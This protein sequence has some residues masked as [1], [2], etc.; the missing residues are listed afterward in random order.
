MAQGTHLR[1]PILVTDQPGRGSCAT[2]MVF[3]TE[4]HDLLIRDHRIHVMPV[5]FISAPIDLLAVGVARI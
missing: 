3:H 2:E 1:D 5:N 4:N